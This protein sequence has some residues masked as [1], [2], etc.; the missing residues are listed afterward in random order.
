MSRATAGTRHKASK[1]RRLLCVT[2]C[3]GVFVAHLFA[4]RRSFP[5]SALENRKPQPLAS[6]LHQWG[7]VTLFHG[8]PSDHVRAI[9]QDSDGMMWFG[10]DGGLVKYDGRRIQ[11]LAPDGPAAAR[12]LALKL[13]GDSVLWIGTDAGA[14]RLINGEIKPI[15]ETRDSAVTAIITP[16]TGR[17]MMTSEQGEVF[18]CAT[19]RDGSLAVHMIKPDDHPLLTI[20]SR[21]HAP[22]RLTSLA[23]TGSTL[24]IG[25]RSRGLLAIDSNQMKAGAT[26]MPDLVKEILSRPRA[27]FVE[28]IE[29]DARG[30]LW[31]GA[32]TS[33]EDSG[34][35]DGRDLM[36]P[37][38]IGAGMGTVTALRADESGNIWVG[39]DARGAFLFRD[40]RGLEQ[41]TFESTGGGLL[42]NHIYS[43]FIDREGVA[44][45]GTDRGVCRYDPHALR[46]EA[47][48]AGAESNFARTLFQSSEGTL[49]C[50]TN[51]GLFGREKDSSW[52]EV[53]E[54]K[55]K[56]IHSIAEDSQ[57]RL[58]VGA[59]TGLFVA[60]KPSSRRNGAVHSAA[61]REF[62][63]VENANGTTDN[64]RAITTFR[65]AVYI[66]NF[67]RGIERLD[68]TTRTLVWPDDSAD[69]REPQVVS[70]HA[71]KE[72]LWIGAAEAGVFLF[73]GKQATID[74]A[75]DE[76][77]GA[78]VWSI[79]GASDDVLWL[80]SARGL[81]ALRQGQLQQVIEGIDARCVV[82]AGGSASEQAVWCATNG[83]GL[84]KVLRDDGEGAPRSAAASVLTSR[85][86]SEQGMP[87]Q[88]A[89]AVMPVRGASGEEVL[90]IGTS[91]GVARYEPGREAPVLNVMRVMGKRVY[92]VEELRGGLN[93]EYPQNSVALD[94]A[95]ISSRTFPEQFQYSFSVLDGEG[96]VVREKRS[97][98][99][100]VLIEGLRPGR[101]R[102]VARAFANDLVP[103]D[104]LQ[105]YFTVARAPFPW[106]ST[107]LSVL[108][109][110]ALIAMWWGYRQNRRLSKT[111]RQ[112]ADTRMQLANETET[113]R[114]RIARDLHDQT[115]ADLRGLMML[116]DQLPP[117]ESKNGHVEP[118]AFRDEIESISTEIRRICE[119]LSPSALANV[120]LAAALEW[121]LADAVT[122]QPP[123]KKFEYEFVCEVGI[124]ETL[125]LNSADQIQIYRIVQ[126]AVSNI[127]RHSAATW[128]KLAVAI[129]VSGEL[130]IRVEDNGCGFEA[131][132]LAKMGRGLTNI[133]S[134]ASLI[135]AEVAWASPSEG[136]TLFLLR[137]RTVKAHVG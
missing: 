3:L 23:L 11:K 16:E 80:A 78:G 29:T 56:V 112:L 113:E 100:Q 119:D 55:G 25:T 116:T 110:F 66:A 9:A 117:N 49:W 48:S 99:S 8:L 135:D 36:R 97:R 6:N 109:A 12:V 18:D 22:L 60:T 65:G 44:W 1:T 50:G 79:A 40:G 51:R 32:E 57:G 62:S 21:G 34:F 13:N 59:A 131:N 46:V 93:L 133:R 31:F 77:I 96:R 125:K 115:L 105:F 72:R 19:A 38:K 94:V 101:Y 136:G 92:S 106:T 30:R 35:Y 24:T 104:A 91:R 121:G 53:R 84:Y 103:S 15:P 98:E 45:F 102:V 137:K 75:L 126:E 17:A 122:H 83:G 39:T 74:H 14:A 52:Q 73:D 4:A 41:F 120:G 5:A 88:N 42:S 81:Y 134:R 111:N 2:L 108:L 27:F 26:R 90:W 71:D 123:E 68:G 67:G 130:L 69:S 63:R 10:T 76:L 28:A 64:I 114:R 86:D 132:K 118:S 89:F 87:S 58:L 37:A 61:R 129:D 95:A 54:L 33:A 7:A 107:A 82:A 43:I 70:L 20:E 47:I 85:I 127:C 128:V 124:E